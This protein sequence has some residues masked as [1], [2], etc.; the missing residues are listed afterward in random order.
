[1][2]TPYCGP[3][4][5]QPGH[6]HHSALLQASGKAH[7]DAAAEVR[8]ILEAQG[9]REWKQPPWGVLSGAAAGNADS[10]GDSHQNVI[11]LL[12]TWQSDRVR[13]SP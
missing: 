5:S 7:E 9:G 13:H 12:S 10:I 8:G 1:M 4:P 2:L 11:K 3:R 6:A